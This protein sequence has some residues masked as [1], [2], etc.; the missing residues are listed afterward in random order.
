M[1][2]GQGVLPASTL[3]VGE[4]DRL[5]AQI[6]KREAAKHASHAAQLRDALAL[7]RVYADAGMELMT[8]SVLALTWRCSEQRAASRLHEARSL[9]RLGA[10]PVM[11]AGLLTVDQGRVVVDVLSAV[12]DDVVASAV[13]ERLRARL[14]QD[15]LVGAVLPPARCADL[16][17]RWLQEAD[18]RGAVDRRRAAEDARAGVD[19]WDGRDGTFDIAIRGVSGLNAQAC[20]QRI[21]ETAEPIGPWDERGVGMRRRDAAVDLILGRTTLPFSDDAVAAATELGID[22]ACPRAGCG[23]SQGQ[24][25]PCGAG[26]HVLVPL[27]TAL[28]T[29]DQPA[30]QVGH[31]PIDN[32]LLQDL[33]L[34]APKLHL[35]WVD[36][37][38]GAPVAM[39]ERTWS[40]ARGDPVDLR[41]ALLDIAAATPPA[42]E[43]GVPLHPDDHAGRIGRSV[44]LPGVLTHPH[45]ADTPGPYATPRRLARLLRLRAPRCEWPGC[46]RRA[47]VTGREGCDLDHDMPWPYGP[48]CGCNEGPACRRHHR[49]KQLGWGKWR[50]PGGGLRW[51]SPTG[52]AW[53]SLLQHE[54]PTPP[55]RPLMRVPVPSPMDG[56][57][58]SELVDALW[59]P[60]DPSCA[61]RDVPAPDDIDPP[62]SDLGDR[63]D[64]SLWSRLDDPTAWIDLP[65]PLER[66]ESAHGEL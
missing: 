40:P 13:W 57:G 33:L 25:V 1:A 37:G 22:L 10:L 28:G 9:E 58:P 12:E 65:V 18:P 55:T 46:G 51:T 61:D 5:T 39:D 50:L 52:R 60:A 63:F 7:E 2:I 43:Q 32:A 66:L 49:I 56:L 35:V 14:E 36:P 15:A 31:G 45:P 62:E 29:G 26:V 19:L 24:S 42:A 6:E 11:A 27:P 47:L 64:G 21:A 48:T 38:S 16:L 8:V 54:P 4:V 59:D 41:R 3:D 23:C 34:A 53:L 44:E 30:E 17:R 20:A